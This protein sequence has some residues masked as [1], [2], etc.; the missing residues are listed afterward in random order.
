LGRPDGGSLARPSVG[1]VVSGSVARSLNG[2]TVNGSITWPLTGHLVSSSVARSLAG[3]AVNGSVTRFHGSLTSQA[4]SSASSAVRSY[5]RRS[6]GPPACS[7]RQQFGHVDRPSGGSA[8]S[9]R[10]PAV[11]R[12][13]VPGD[14]ATNIAGGAE[15]DM[16]ACIVGA[17]SARQDLASS[18]AGSPR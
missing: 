2:R 1:R 5:A 11:F 15:A 4:D 17:G 12:A 7:P 10:A 18:T 16:T 9:I 3:S 14:G 6:F 8:G 13:G